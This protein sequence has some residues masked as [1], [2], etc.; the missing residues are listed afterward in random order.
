MKFSSNEAC[1]T[2][3]CGTP[4]YVGPEILE[5]DM[6]GTKCDMWRL[7]VIVFILL[8]GYPSF[9]EENQSIFARFEEGNINFMMSIGCQFH[10][11]QRIE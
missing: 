5:G 1:L 2:T 7:C 8:G 10:K 9:I 3:Q 4:G 11:L 6:Y